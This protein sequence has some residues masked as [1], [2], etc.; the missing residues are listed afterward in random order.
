MFSATL[1]QGKSANCW[2]TTARS[3]PGAVTG[4]SP[5]LTAPALGASNPAAMRRH[6]VLPQPEGPTMATNSRSRIVRSTPSSVTKS[7]P[8]RL[9]TLRTSSNVIDPIPAPQDIP[10]RRRTAA[11][12]RRSATSITSPTIPMAII[13]AMTVGVETLP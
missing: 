8:S 2:N 7:A 11:S 1:F 3:G 5:T 13:P 6:V 12:A 10:R 9:K 4:L